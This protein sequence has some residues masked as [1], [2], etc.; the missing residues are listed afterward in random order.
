MSNYEYSILSVAILWIIT[1]IIFCGKQEKIDLIADD[2]EN[3]IFK[4]IKD[5]YGY[6]QFRFLYNNEDIS[7][8]RFV[9]HY[10]AAIKKKYL[11]KNCVEK[12]GLFYDL[13]SPLRELLR[14][15]IN[16]DD[17]SYQDHFNHYINTIG[18]SDNFIL[19]YEYR[20]NFTKELDEFNFLDEHKINSYE[21]CKNV[22]SQQ[23]IKMTQ[24]AMFCRIKYGR[25]G[26]NDTLVL[27]AV[28][29]I[30]WIKKNFEHIE[31]LR[32]QSADTSENDQIVN[33]NSNNITI[34]YIKGFSIC[35]LLF[36]SLGLNLKYYFQAKKYNIAQLP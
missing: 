6:D 2:I 4:R 16:S 18:T 22:L 5:E 1:T 20:Y 24:Q 32:L 31:V 14:K 12:I 17:A 7:N 26:L 30:E 35:L 9:L 13:K 28:D 21:D 15:C 25:V 3:S 23:L 19:L 27:S 29:K 34:S 33:R 11:C 8:N 36:I 10:N